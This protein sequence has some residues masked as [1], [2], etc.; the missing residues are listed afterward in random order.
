MT[1]VPATS[2]SESSVTL[3]QHTKRVRSRQGGKS[4]EWQQSLVRLRQP[5]PPHCC[6]ESEHHRRTKGSY[7]SIALANQLPS[8]TL[9][10]AAEHIQRRPTRKRHR[11]SAASDKTNNR[12]EETRAENHVATAL[13]RRLSHTTIS[14]CPGQQPHRVHP[15]MSPTE[16]LTETGTT[17]P[18]KVF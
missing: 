12:A 8:N 9:H 7:R 1:S 15:K 13:N 4:P 16:P 2:A 3:L 5:H 17:R 6:N 14:R 11:D 10:I 18:E